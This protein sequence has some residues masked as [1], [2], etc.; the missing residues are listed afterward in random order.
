MPI[1]GNKVVTAARPPVIVDDPFDHVLERRQNR[2]VQI[3][4]DD[5]PILPLDPFLKPLERDF[6]PLENPLPARDLTGIHRVAV[7]VVHAQAVH[8]I[9]FFRDA[10][11]VALPRHQIEHPN[12]TGH[13]VDL[14]QRERRPIPHVQPP[15]PGGANQRRGM[16]AVHPEREFQLRQFRQ[17]HGS[18]PSRTARDASTG[19]DNPETMSSARLNSTDRRSASSSCSSRSSCD[20][21]KRERG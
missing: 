17:A 12:R 6:Q 19:K 3:D 13:R 11:N 5:V 7:G 15:A 20:R 8:P 14:A 21:E 16:G 2:I 4:T 9:A 1:A 18:L 10:G